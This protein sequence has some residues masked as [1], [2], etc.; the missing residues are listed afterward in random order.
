[1]RVA[2]AVE[3]RKNVEVCTVDNIKIRSTFSKRDRAR[4]IS[5]LD[6]N[7]CMQRAFKRAGIPIWYTQGF[8]PHAY[9]MFPLALTLG[10]ES[11]CEIMD[12]AITEEM[13]FTDIKDRM[14]AVLPQGLKINSVAYQIKK[15]TDIEQAEYK[16]DIKGNTTLKIDFDDFI[17]RETIEVEKKTKKGIAHIDIKPFIDLISCETTDNI[18]EVVIRLPAGTEM[19]I[20]PNLVFDEFFKGLSYEAEIAY[21]ERTKILCADSEIFS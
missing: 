19:N 1:M 12:F 3:S 18:L 7:R 2:Q 4:F 15:H 11:D 9:I 13:D 14:N 6:L 16:V 17:T 21:I 10:V 20:N 8:N 5:H